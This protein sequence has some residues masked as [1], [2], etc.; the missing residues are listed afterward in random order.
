LSTRSL[1][2][3]DPMSTIRRNDARSS[4]PALETRGVEFE[5]QLA[6]A[7]RVRPGDKLVWDDDRETWLT[8]SYEVFREITK[9]TDLF[10]FPGAEAEFAPSWLDR[11]FYV[12]YEGGPKKFNFIQGEEHDQLHRWWMKQFSPR[13]VEEWRHNIIRPHIDRLVDDFIDDGR[14]ELMSQFARLVPLPII[15]GLMDIPANEEL[16]ERY[17]RVSHS[18]GQ[19]RWRLLTD[20]A[21]S[22]D[23]REQATKVGQEMRDI[24]MPIVQD[25]RS[26]ERDDL[27]SRL[28]KATDELI[29]GECDDEAVYAN[30]TTLFEAGIGTGAVA[31]GEI[32]YVLCK[33]SSHQELLRSEPS[34]IPNFVEEA[35]R[36]TTPALYIP[37]Q[38][39]EDMTFQGCP[40]Q[41]GDSI[42]AVALA[43]GRDEAHYPHPDDMDLARQAPRDHVAFGFGPRSCAGH[44]VGRA[45]LQEVVAAF[46]TRLPNLRL[47]PA[48]GIPRRGGAGPR[49]PWEALHV[50]FDRA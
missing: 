36:L 50:V 11:E 26:G 18:F 4:G 35:L 32:V 34:L 29:D 7:G 42:A 20:P 44:A 1:E 3:E 39:T 41:R 22:A 45:E 17:N 21:A 13:V 15:L 14:A 49:R 16:I 5:E 47:D 25:R 38:V 19:L 10:Q 48:Q 33:S 8:G 46:V 23:L 43:A 9:R 37:R 28:W 27:I 2:R 30:V 12:W 6:L 40:L 31:I 24:L